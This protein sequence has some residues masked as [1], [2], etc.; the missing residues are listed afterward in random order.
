MNKDK[1]NERSGIPAKKRQVPSRKNPQV[2]KAFKR[3][4]FCCI[5]FFPIFD[6]IESMN[7]EAIRTNVSSGQLKPELLV[8]CNGKS[9][10]F[11]AGMLHASSTFFAGWSRSVRWILITFSLGCAVVVVVWRVINL[12]SQTTRRRRLR[13]NG[14]RDSRDS[15]SERKDAHH[16]SSVLE[17]LAFLTLSVI[18]IIYTAKCSPRFVMCHISIRSTG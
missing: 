18:A 16:A 15:E 5:L 10:G 4:S 8:Q 6:V 14:G 7:L 2:W 13:W 12:I 1:T 11:P 9:T 3:L 17:W